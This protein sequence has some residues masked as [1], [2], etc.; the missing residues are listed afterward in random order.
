MDHILANTGK[1]K[2][3]SRSE[4]GEKYPDTIWMKMTHNWEFFNPTEGICSQARKWGGE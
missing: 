4:A 3:P 1:S 2:R